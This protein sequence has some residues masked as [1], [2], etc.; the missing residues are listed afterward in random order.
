VASYSLSD[1]ALADLDAISDYIIQDNPTRAVSFVDELTEKFQRI[2]ERPVSF[3]TRDLSP[4]CALPYT[5]I[6]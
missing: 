5:G 4:G 1:E 3:R 6:T 2:A